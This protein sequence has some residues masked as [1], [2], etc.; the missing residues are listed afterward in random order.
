[1]TDSAPRSP[2]RVRSTTETLLSIV[3][4]LEAVLV[5]FVALTVFGLRALPPAPALVGGAVLLVVL[6]LLGRL[7]RYGWGVWLG[8]VMQAVLIATGIFVPLMFAIGA[9][10]AA[11]W[12]Y[13]F[14]RGRQIDRSRADVLEALAS[15]TDTTQPKEKP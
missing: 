9:G 15:E 8:W 5:F 13:C 4:A 6:V 11:I 12:I 10:F 14:V 7:V 1:M 3:L 2:R